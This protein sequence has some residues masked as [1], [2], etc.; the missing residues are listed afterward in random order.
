MTSVTFGGFKHAGLLLA[1]RPLEANSA[2]YSRCG[3]AVISR[4]STAT[5]TGHWLQPL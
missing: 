5:D 4:G 3:G 1:R 2:V